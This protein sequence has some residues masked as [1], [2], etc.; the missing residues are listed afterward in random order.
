VGDINCL[1]ISI[2]GKVSIDKVVTKNLKVVSSRD[3][4]INSIVGS[5]I[6]IINGTNVENNEK[7]R[8]IK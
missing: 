1:E 2:H 5:S 7:I 4:K 8:G 6:S 3:S